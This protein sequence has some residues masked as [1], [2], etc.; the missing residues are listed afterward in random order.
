MEVNQEI[1]PKCV[2]QGLGKT[3]D[4]NQDA[5]EETGGNQAGRHS[6]PIQ[7][8]AFH[9]KK[10][11]KQNGSVWAVRRKERMSAVRVKGKEVCGGKHWQ[12]HLGILLD[13]ASP[14]F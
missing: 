3:Q 6:E 1:I 10:A 14:G 11:S 9:L 12:A 4:T 7:K 8:N 13:R 2:S 5:P